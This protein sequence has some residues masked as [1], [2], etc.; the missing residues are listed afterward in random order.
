VKVLDPACTLSVQF[1][2]C[3]PLKTI[4]VKLPGKEPETVPPSG[5]AA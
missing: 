5:L 1:W 4:H 3:E 2:R